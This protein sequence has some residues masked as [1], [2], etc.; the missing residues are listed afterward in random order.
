MKGNGEEMKRDVD[1][2]DKAV[3]ELRLESRGNPTDRLKTESELAKIEK[4]KLDKLE[5]SDAD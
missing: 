3:N 1:E 5:V 4:D 2:F